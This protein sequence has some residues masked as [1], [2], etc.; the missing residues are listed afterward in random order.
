MLPEIPLYD[1]LKRTQTRPLRFFSLIFTELFLIMIIFFINWFNTGQSYPYFTQIFFKNFGKYFSFCIIGALYLILGIIGT[2][3]VETR[4][5]RDRISGIISFHRLTPL[6]PDNLIWGYI[7]G[8]TFELYV[9]F[10]IAFLFGLIGVFTGGISFSKYI[11]STLMIFFSSIFFQINSARSGLSKPLSYKLGVRTSAGF[12]STLPIFFSFINFLDFWFFSPIPSIIYLFNKKSLGFYSTGIPFLYFYISP[13]TYSFI[14][15]ILF[16]TIFYFCSRRKIISEEGP[17]F[18][19]REAIV[20]LFIISFLLT[21]RIMGILN[22]HPEYFISPKK[23]IE[24]VSLFISLIITILIFSSFVLLSFTFPRRLDFIH[25][26][27]RKKK[28]DKILWYEDDASSLTTTFIISLIFIFYFII[29][30]LF[31]YLS[32]IKIDWF[33]TIM[34]LFIFIPSLFFL[35]FIIEGCRMRFEK[36][37]DNISGL[38][39]FFWFFVIPFIFIIYALNVEKAK[40]YLMGLSPLPFFIPYDIYGKELKVFSEIKKAILVSFIFTNIVLFFTFL[41]WKRAKLIFIR[42][43]S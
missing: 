25:K 1:A 22:L 17:I 5:T 42:K 34:K 4:I 26:F 3:A 37:G 30:H 6:N 40:I 12:A 14:L 43:Y 41:F 35:T 39:I 29:L 32:G 28:G 9:A 19:K 27:V 2:S 33:G 8:S 21:G 18:T 36:G 38:I 11:I 13:F 31:C 23:G 10:F 20:I 7:L 15:W 24:D 16:G